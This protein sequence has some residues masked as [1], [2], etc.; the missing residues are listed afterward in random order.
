MKLNINGKSKVLL[1]TRK[2]DGVK[3]WLTKPSWDCDWYWSFG[4]L[5]NKDEH[6]HLSGYADGRNIHIRDALL[7]DYNLSKSLKDDDNL[8]LFC[9]LMLTAY[10]LNESVAVIGR[11]GSHCTRNHLSELIKNEDEVTRINE[12]V[13]PAIFNKLSEIFE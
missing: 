3:I 7:E 2:S 4:Y 13:L 5:G 6:Y 9:E 11:G 10:T 8:W 1:G 12:I